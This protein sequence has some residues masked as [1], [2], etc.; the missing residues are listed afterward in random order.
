ME[1]KWYAS[2]TIWAN[3]VMLAGA[4]ILETTGHEIS[5]V[6]TAT[7]MSIINWLL[8]TITKENIVW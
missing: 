7:A 2:R 5:P 3:V 8:R 1:K 4:I 6:A